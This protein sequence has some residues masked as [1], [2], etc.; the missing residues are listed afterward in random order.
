MEG[1]EPN[2]LELY[3]TKQVAKKEGDD[4]E[5]LPLPTR[6]MSPRQAAKLFYDGVHL[7]EESE[8]KPKLLQ[9]RL[10]ELAHKAIKRKQFQKQYYE[11]SAS[12]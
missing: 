5:V 10:P 9:D 11:V 3:P 8:K 7:L 6:N 1:G 2:W 12:S 4:E